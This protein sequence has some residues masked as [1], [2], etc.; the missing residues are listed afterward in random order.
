MSDFANYSGFSPLDY[1]R[2]YYSVPGSESDGLLRFLVSVFSEI[3]NSP[4]VLDFGSGPTLI[5]AIPAARRARAI[6]LGDYVPENRQYISRWLDG[7]DQEFDWSP[8]V[9]RCLELEDVETS[10]LNIARRMSRVRD[11]VTRV[12]H[13]DASRGIPIRT[14]CK[15]E[16]IVCN[17]CLDAIT[18]SR[19]EWQLYI[20]RLARLLKPGGTLVLSSLRQ[21]EFYEFGSTRYANVLLDIDD[22]PE[23]FERAGFDAKTVR[24]ESAQPDHHDREYKGVIFASASLPLHLPKSYWMKNNDYCDDYYTQ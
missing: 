18:N 3:T 23:A 22:M 12:E 19:Y 16:V 14:R 7:E 21:T 13:C 2:A 6:H 5:S 10:P 17:Y 24:V 4:L 20:E 11:L 1:L 15:Y 8:Y 9:A